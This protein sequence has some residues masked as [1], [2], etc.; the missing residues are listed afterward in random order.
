MTT[1]LLILLCLAVICIGGHFLAAYYTRKETAKCT[2]PGKMVTVHGEPM[3]VRVQGEGDG[4]VAV[5]LSGWSTAVP[6][7]DFQPLVRQLQSLG[8][9]TAIVEKFG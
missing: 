4:P 7:V 1:V 5:L 9:P 6:S 3:H 2:A 8:I